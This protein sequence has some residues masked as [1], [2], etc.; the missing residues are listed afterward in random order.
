MTKKMERAEELQQRINA[1]EKGEFQNGA[2]PG[3][4][5]SI[6]SALCILLM[7]ALLVSQLAY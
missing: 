7:L 4:L 2:Y 3:C 1:Q 5:F 6:S